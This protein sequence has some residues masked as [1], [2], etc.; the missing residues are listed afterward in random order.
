MLGAVWASTAALADPPR[1]QTAIQDF[2]FHGTQPRLPA[3]NPDPL[4]R[5][6]A[7]VE[8]STC[9]G[10]HGVYE[11]DDPR[12]EQYLPH[13]RWSYSMMSQSYRDPVFLAQM[14]IAEKDASFSGDTCLRCHA[15]M[16]WTQKH[17]FPTDGSALVGSDMDGVACSVCHRMVNP[18]E[19]TYP[20]PP[21]GSPPEDATL[22][23]DQ[24]RL[25]LEGLGINRPPNFGNGGP[26]AANSYVIDNQDRR[27][28]PFDLG[29]FFYHNWAQSSFHTTGQQCAACHDISNAIFT[30]ELDGTYTLNPLEA[31]HPTG[32]KYDMYPMDRL[33]SEWSRSAFATGPVTMLVPNPNGAGT[34]GRYSFD[35][36]SKVWEYN[37]TTN[38]YTETSTFLVN[39]TTAYSSCQDCHMP[40][41]AGTGCNPFLGSPP[42]NV[43][44]HN[45]AGVNSWVLKGVRSLFDP[46]ET[47]MDDPLRAE[48]SVQRSIAMQQKALDL[49]LVR[50]GANLRVRIVNQTGHKLPSGFSEG[51][52]MWIN[53]RFF[54]GADVLV[55]ERGA[56]DGTTATL[57]EGDTK[58]YQSKHGLDAAMAVIAGLPEGPSFHLDLNNK[59]YLDNRIP[60][61]GFTN[62]GFAA[63][64]ASPVGYAYADGQYWD[65]TLFAVPTGAVR[66]EVR[67]FHQT[68]TREYAE[69]LRDN[70]TS[71]S[72]AIR[73]P[74]PNTGQPIG[75]LAYNQW[76]AHG[77]SAPVE[78][79]F[80]QTAV[81]S[82]PADIATSGNP[83]PNAGP[84]G[85]ITGEDFDLFVMAFFT[86]Q[87]NAQ[88][89]LIADVATA[90]SS[91][92]WSGPDGF[93]TG[94]DFDAFVILYFTN[95]AG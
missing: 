71:A 43:P 85:F 90:G 57:T 34:V 32:N 16:G 30:K 94:E 68:T 50:L 64:Q 14:Q 3:Y 61:R 15:P 74:N 65:D 92:P 53:V 11:G 13:G 37:E 18:V 51:R 46:A 91:D 42:R 1:V 33:Y 58:V 8:P 63:V 52:R 59:V 67:V 21:A 35:G 2:Y 4:V 69:F 5:F 17:N 24:D 60:P 19:Q 12:W 76:L 95:C 41:T 79:A 38:E 80:A 26:L 47:N 56:Y 39:G 28:G 66:A 29:E 40:K 9:Q 23:G 45:F 75:L 31:K 27:R 7:L 54:N 73:S 55:A 70:A 89:V 25:V 84:D 48:R 10:C 81:S 44:V 22:L 77:K 78:K 36:V 93:I 6:D 20:S 86:E 62:A 87:T 83:D 82:C 88:G 72:P 49:E